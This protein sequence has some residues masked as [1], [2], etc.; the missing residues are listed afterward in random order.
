MCLFSDG[1]YT[2][3]NCTINLKH[4][5]SVLCSYSPSNNILFMDSGK[6]TVIKAIKQRFMYDLIQQMSF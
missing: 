2:D 1:Y 4:V 3:V 6:T 5:F